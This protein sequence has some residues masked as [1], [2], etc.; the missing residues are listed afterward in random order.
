MMYV[1]C[2]YVWRDGLSQQMLYLL[3]QLERGSSAVSDTRLALSESAQNTAHLKLTSFSSLSYSISIHGI[4]NDLQSL[5]TFDHR[6][7]TILKMVKCTCTR[8]VWL[9]NYRV[10]I[11]L[12]L[13]VVLK[14]IQLFYLYVGFG[15][16]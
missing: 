11:Y 10:L 13:K 7:N 14:V 16:C 2:H 8:F 5:T 6:M 1:L 4:S 15:C 9:I 3:T 12:L